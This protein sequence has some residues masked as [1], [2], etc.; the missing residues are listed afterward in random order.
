MVNKVLASVD[1]TTKTT[2]AKFTSI[3]GT[4]KVSVAVGGTLPVRNLDGLS[5][6]PAAKVVVK[7]T[8]QSVNGVGVSGTLI[9]Q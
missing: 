2:A 4:F 3:A 5:A 6:L 1:N 9:I 7:N 8:T